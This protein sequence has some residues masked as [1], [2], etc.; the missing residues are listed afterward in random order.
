MYVKSQNI[1]I[2][3]NQVCAGNE[4]TL[5]ASSTMSED[6]IINYLWDFNND[7]IYN[8]AYGKTV[9]FITSQNNSPIKLKIITQNREYFYNKEILSYSKP[10]ALF[11]I[12]N[13]CTDDTIR[14]IDYSYSTSGL[15][16]QYSW[17][18]NNDGISES[19]LIGSNTHIYREA[20]SYNPK[21]KITTEYGCTSEYSK[22]IIIKEKPTINISVE[23]TCLGDSTII[24]NGNTLV[25]DSISKMFWEFGDGNTSSII[26]NNLKYLYNKSET[27]IAKVHIEHVNGCRNELSYPIEI[28]PKPFI[29]LIFS[30]D[31][32]MYEGAQLKVYVDGFYN[33]IVWSTGETLPEITIDKAGI[34]SINAT[35]QGCTSSKSF[36][37]I[38]NSIEDMQKPSLESKIITPNGDGI[39]DRL[40]FQKLATYPSCRF[41]VY[42]SRGINIYSDNNFQNQWDMKI[43]G[44]PLKTGSYYYIIEF[45]AKRY[46]GNFNVLR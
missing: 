26:T 30:G 29:N 8:D 34:Y 43:D 41:I 2:Q 35:N 40:N 24:Q 17:D 32:V 15:L 6:S 36:R 31:T 23:G 37:V 14:F 45:G 9:T 21:L 12:M 1:D 25:K 7:G 3:Y 18:F 38:V 10:V 27:F 39:N 46:T 22:N 42:N 28:N 4:T 44:V 16:R 5:I 20:K 11:A 33:S 19:N 13:G